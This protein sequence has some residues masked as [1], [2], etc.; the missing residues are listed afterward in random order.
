MKWLLKPF[1]FLIGLMLGLALGYVLAERQPVPPAKALMALQQGSGEAL[2]PGHPP[3]EN[4]EPPQDAELDQQVKSLT[5]MLADDPD[6]VEVVTALGNLFFDHSRWDEAQRWYRKALELKPGDVNVMTDYAVVLRN[7]GKG[8]EAL[9]ILNTVLA[10]DPGHW[11][12]L[13]NKVIVLN[14]DLHRHADAIEELKKL[15]SMRSSHPDIPDLDA[16]RKK[17]ENP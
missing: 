3:V 9:D 1:P 14:F 6:N 10:K 15:E 13:Y 12:A 2:P 11:Q 8:Q 7:L 5:T 4:T 16:L 17:I